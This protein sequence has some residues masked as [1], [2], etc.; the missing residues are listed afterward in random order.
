MAMRPSSSLTVTLGSPALPSLPAG[1]ENKPENAQ[2]GL[3]SQAVRRHWA[4]RHL[5]MSTR[6]IKSP[7]PSSDE[8]WPV[9]GL[10]HSVDGAFTTQT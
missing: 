8:S 1:S 9:T 2:G 4:Q 7:Q 6:T 3:T 5:P 10:C